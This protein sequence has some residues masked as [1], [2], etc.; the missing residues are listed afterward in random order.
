MH[1]KENND[2]NDKI[3]IGWKM[4]GQPGLLINFNL[5]WN[6]NPQDHSIPLKMKAILLMAM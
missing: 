5:G 1:A 3:I 2:I 4:L 6:F